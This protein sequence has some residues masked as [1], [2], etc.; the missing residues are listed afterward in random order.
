M[1]GSARGWHTL[2][3]ARFDEMWSLHPPTLGRNTFD[4]RSVQTPRYFQAFGRAYSFSGQTA[5]PLP[6]AR[7]PLAAEPLTKIGALVTAAGAGTAQPALPSPNGLLVNWYRA[8]HS[9]GLHRDDTRE[10][11]HGAPVWSLSW[12]HRRRFC[13]RPRVKN[14]R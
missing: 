13:L 11:V 3:P 5:A 6:L 14:A 4:G 12:G 2:A 9:I 10:L 1:S 7:V 8:E